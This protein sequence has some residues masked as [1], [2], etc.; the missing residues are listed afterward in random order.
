MRG[1]DLLEEPREGPFDDIGIQPAAGDSGSAVGVALDAYHTNYG[2]ER[3]FTPG[4]SA[5]G[6]SYFGPEFSGDEIEAYLETYGYPYR[7]LSGSERNQ[8][9]DDLRGLDRTV[10]IFADRALQ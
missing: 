8:F 6:G 7:K 1:V 3:V 10:L 4:I 5:Q 9:L 2:R